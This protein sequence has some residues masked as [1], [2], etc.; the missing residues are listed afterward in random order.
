M[1]A[2]KRNLAANIKNSI[3]DGFNFQDLSPAAIQLS[4]ASLSAFCRPDSQIGPKWVCN[5][6]K[7]YRAV[8]APLIVTDSEFENTNTLVEDLAFTEKVVLARN[9]FPG[10]IDF[11]KVA[12]LQGLDLGGSTIGRFVMSD[13][14]VQGTANFKDVQSNRLFDLGNLVVNGDLSLAR[15]VIRTETLSMSNV[16]V[17]GNLDLSEM[18]VE[19]GLNLLRTVAG[20]LLLKSTV[21]DG[22][23]YL[24]DLDAGLG[25]LTGLRLNGDL[26]AYTNRF[27]DHL[28]IAGVAIVG[29]LEFSRITL[30]N[31]VD[32]IAK[33]SGNVNLNST[34]LFGGI[35]LHSSA[36]GGDVQIQGARVFDSISV[37]DVR[38]SGSLLISNST[39]ASVS[40]RDMFSAGS[41][42]VSNPP[43]NSPN[44]SRARQLSC[45]GS[46]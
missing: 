6:D 30:C 9:K 33:V 17:E 2:L 36:V 28:S 43:D 45:G 18:R 24:S 26:T 42:A 10:S 41:I 13:A 7:V 44:A 34:S 5:S 38:V 27:R 23:L 35:D 25:D 31:G 1:R 15:A 12:F 46:R 21:S 32:G 16:A 20:G 14:A 40:G 3:I 29:N 39:A 19:K 22:N 11:S 8:S 4:G 37:P